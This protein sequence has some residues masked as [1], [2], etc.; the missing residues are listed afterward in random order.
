MD[1]YYS[2]DLKCTPKAH[3]LMTWSIVWCYWEVVEPF[4]GGTLQEVLRSLEVCPLFL[5]LF[6]P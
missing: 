6:A 4:R 5:F 2:S 3:V 1:Q